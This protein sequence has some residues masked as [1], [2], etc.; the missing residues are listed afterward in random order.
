MWR[1]RNKSSGK[2]AARAPTRQNRLARRKLGLEVGDRVRII[3]ILPDLKDPTYDLLDAE[4]QEMRTAEL[5]RFC[6]Q[7]VF[8]IYGFDRFGY[9]ELE[10]SKSPSVRK[11]FGLNTIWIEPEFLAPV[12]RKA[13]K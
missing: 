10:V 11:E 5:F 8:T 4:H 2:A 9:V 12:R 3:D 13:E 7:R 6:L 1:T